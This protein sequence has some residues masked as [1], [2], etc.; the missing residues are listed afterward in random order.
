MAPP[1]PLPLA[2]I[3]TAG[4]A[5]RRFGSDKALARLGGVTLLQR[6]AHSLSGGHP[7][8]IVA[9]PGRYDLAAL[10][11]TD[12]QTVPDTRPGEGPLA[13]LEAGLSVLAPGRWAAYAAVD[14]PHLT[15]AFW[16]RLASFI[17]PQAQAV[18]GHSQDGRAQPL[19][20][21]YHASALG[22][23]TALLDD[24]ERR[25][26]ALLRQL[27]TVKVTWDD[28]KAAAPQAYRNVNTP[29]DLG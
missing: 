11:L 1:P 23:V 13:G 16:G 18:V 8:L 19:A 6:V 5:S 2:A 3:I 27:D 24:G 10:H 25:I 14:L 28:L 4:G 29:A 21:L 12:W 15:P 17:Q 26:L 22:E 20:A 7:K 9:P